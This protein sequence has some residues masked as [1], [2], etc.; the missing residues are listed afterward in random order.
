M[1]SATDSAKKPRARWAWV[2]F[3]LLTTVGD[4]GCA[5]LRSYRENDRPAFG[6]EPLSTDP[7]AKDRSTTGDLYADRFS[8]GRKPGRPSIARNASDSTPELLP[9][10][11]RGERDAEEVLSASHDERKPAS[12]GAPGRDPDP[13][14]ALLAPVALPSLDESN[15]A[16]A[17]RRTEP[18]PLEILTAPS[19]ADE[20]R[21]PRRSTPPE[22]VA[23]PIPAATPPTPSLATILAESRGRLNALTSYQVK[24]TRQERVGGTLNP[25]EDVILSIRRNPKA[26]RLEWPTGQNKGREV[27]YSAVANGGLMHVNM[28]ATLVPMPRL[29]LPP[30]S[31][32]ATRNSRHPITEAGFDTILQGME[33]ALRAQRSNDP[34]LGQIR[35]EGLEKPEELDRPGHKV[36]RVTPTNETWVV[37][38][39]PETR[40]PAQVEATAGNG[41][42]LERFVFRDPAFDLPV[43][44]RA[45]S[46]DPDSRWGPAKGLLGRFARAGAGSTKETEAR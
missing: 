13:R 26:V 25:P 45:E 21:A 30:D 8:Q 17:S 9:P 44:A 24:M 22:L 7:W 11:S 39:D 23:V 14:I 29:S 12:S 36:V 2:G 42:L 32:L 4:L 31:P 34:S 38:L 43:L 20:A 46:F 18:D 37:Y 6:T 5:Q 27:I 19:P 40:L 41:D 3:A 16:L 35:Y 33:T 1:V 10:E 15:P 28:G